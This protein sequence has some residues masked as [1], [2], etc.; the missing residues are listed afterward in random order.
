MKNSFSR[1]I[2]IIYILSLSLCQIQICY[3]QEYYEEIMYPDTVNIV[4]MLPINYDTIF[5]GGNTQY[6]NGG[7]YKSFNGGATWEFAGLDGFSVYSMIRGYGDT[8]YVSANRSVFRT[9]DLGEYWERLLQLERNVVSLARLQSGQIFAGF[10]GGIMRSLDNGLTWDTSLA[11][12]QNSFI[13]AILPVSENEIY[14]GG[15]GYT[16]FDAGVFVSSDLGETWDYI[17]LVGYNIQALGYNGDHE[18]FAGCYYDGLLKT[19]D[20]GMTWETVFPHRD[21]L[22]IAI[23]FDEMYLG[24]GN[25]SYFNGGIFYSSDNGVTWEDHTYNL[26][27]KDITDVAITDDQ[28]FYSLSRYEAVVLGP[29]FNRS[30]NPVFIS[31]KNSPRYLDINIFPN[32]ASDLLHI[33][34]PSVYVT[35]GKLNFLIY[36]QTGHVVKSD[37]TFISPDSKTF[38]INIINLIPGIYYLKIIMGQSKYLHKFIV[39]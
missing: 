9:G 26:T 15:T 24:C 30:V 17:G 33:S 28:Y 39:Q 23:D 11:L 13:N 29:P 27:N 25:Q 38:N 8:I 20:S 2:R 10:G 35:N 37:T 6:A 7:V 19:V 3:P 1:F 22:S 5:I 12:N 4:S 16:S 14:A 34:I 18:L 31:D 32:P 36:D 21:V